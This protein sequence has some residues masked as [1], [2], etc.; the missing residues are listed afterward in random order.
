MNVMFLNHPETTL[1]PPPLEKLSST[2]LKLVPGAKKFGKHCS[3]CIAKWILHHW[4]TR[5][6]PE[7]SNIEIRLIPETV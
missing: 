1:S 2:K 4:T 6:V 3:K 7:R 5:E